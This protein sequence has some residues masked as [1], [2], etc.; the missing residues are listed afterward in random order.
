[1]AGM[2]HSTEGH[3]ELLYFRM[4]VLT[5]VSLARQTDIHVFSD[6]SDQAIAAV[7]YLRVVDTFGVLSVGFLMGK[8]KLAPLKGHTIPRLELCGAV[9]ASEIGETV[10]THLNMS[11]DRVHYYTDSKVVLGYIH[12][13]T[14]RFFNYVCNRVE[15]FHSVSCP[16]QW[17]HIPTDQNPADAATRGCL[18]SLNTSVHHWISG[19]TYLDTRTEDFV[20]EY[21][22]ISMENDKEIRQDITSCKTQVTLNIFTPEFL[23]RFSKW[24]TLVHKIMCLKNLFR[25]RQTTS[26]ADCS[27]LYDPKL[28]TDYVLFIILQVQQVAYSGE[29]ANLRNGKSIP[30]SSKV[31]RLDFFSLMTLASYAL[32]E[33]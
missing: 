25:R 22:F 19:P 23:S 33:D 13:T 27:S 29:L 5:S 31:L 2:A 16:S 8:Y 20:D 11:L 3:Q 14:R 4:I 12:N 6:S 9:R 7:P 21:P 32:K 1:M 17:L 18:T 28:K 24:N 26:K 15:K 10:A 30:N